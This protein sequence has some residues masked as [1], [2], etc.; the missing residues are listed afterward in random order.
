M[1]WLADVYNLFVDNETLFSAIAAIFAIIVGISFFIKRIGYFFSFFIKKIGGVFRRKPPVP[2]PAPG[3]PTEVLVNRLLALQKDLSS[4]EQDREGLLKA[5]EAL[6]QNTG[7][8]HEVERKEALKAVEA[9]NTEKAEAL[10]QSLANE[11]ERQGS[12]ANVEAAECWR[13]IG[14]LAFLHDTEKSIRAYYKATELDPANA[15]GWNQLG[16]LQFRKGLLD[17]AMASFERVLSLGNQIDNLEIIAMATGNLGIIF[18]TRGELDEAEAMCRKSLGLNKE[19]GRKEGMANQYGNLGN[20][21]RTRGDLD[22]AEAMYRKSLGLD[23]ELGRKEGM[24]N[25]F[26]NLGNIFMTRGD[27]DEARLH[28]QQAI[29][30][31]KE[32]GMPH[33]VEKVERIMRD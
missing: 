18:K 6:Q 29:D 20:I 10:F 5:I 23:E 8:E 3:D 15:D 33:M 26:G 28:W 12:A 19:L 22:E 14:A 9:G 11:K 17:A 13:Y 32:V 7:P 21:F 27:L 4:A 24:A 16:R 1:E 30:L 2:P 25:T 31:Y